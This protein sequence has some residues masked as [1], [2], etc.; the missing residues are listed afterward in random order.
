MRFLLL[1]VVVS[2]LLNQRISAAPR[3]YSAY[4]YALQ[5]GSEV[6][7]TFRGERL[8]RI[9]Q[10]LAYRPGLAASDWRVTDDATVTARVAVA[11]DCPLGIHALRLC[12]ETGISDL[13]TVYVGVLPPVDESEPN[14]S[15]QE[16]QGVPRECMILGRIQ[17]EDADRFW[18]EA[19]EGDR[20]SLE[21]HGLRLG[22]GSLFDPAIE[23]FGPDGQLVA[24][25]DDTALTQ[26]DVFMEQRALQTGRYTVC[27][28]EAVNGG[29]DRCW[30]LLHVGRYPRP[31][32]ARPEG[33]A[34]GDLLD[35]T[36][37]PTSF[38][39]R[40]ALGDAVSD[41]E[42][43]PEDEYGVAPSPLMLRVTDLVRVAETEPN[44]AVQTAQS[45]SVPCAVAATLSVPGDV[46]Q[47]RFTAAA[48]QVVDVA[49]ISRRVLRAPA[50]TVLSV[51]HVDGRFIAANDDSPGPDAYLRFTAPEGGEYNIVVRDHLDRGG[52][53]FAY[54]LELRPVQP[55]LTLYLPER[56]FNQSIVLSV[57]RGNR[58]AVMLAG[59]RQ[60]LGGPVD[61]RVE[62][63][64]EGLTVQ[65]L[66]IPADRDRIPL[67]FSAA[68]TAQPQG[69]LVPIAGQVQQGERPV[70]GK[71]HQRQ[72]LVLGLNNRDM[73]GYDADRLAVAVVREA[74]LKI[75]VHQPCVP[76]VRE[77]SLELVIR[78]ERAA[79]FT[80]PVNLQMLYAPPGV[81]SP[82]YVTLAEGATE[83]HLP[84]TAVGSAQIG[85][86]PIVV[87]A[88]GQHEG[89]SFAVASQLV[90]LR[91]EE[92]YLKLAFPQASIEQG[93]TAQ[94]TLAVE[95]HHEFDAAARAELV[96]LPPGVTAQPCEFTHGTANLVFT[97]SADPTARPGRHGGLMCR[98]RV[99]ENQEPV[100]HILGAGYLRVDMP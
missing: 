32:S 62:G 52:D 56:E 63:L 1:A 54:R 24:R 34:P 76:L 100:T 43:Y 66:T 29:D 87:I 14:N 89:D 92:A 80:A 57:P 8:S 2:G 7:V 37:T 93:T 81:S 27:V 69:Y 86:W 44:N 95:Y 12:T 33:G 9:R 30:Y 5:R 94:L 13:R 19:A 36:W 35:V 53:E 98:V 91:V 6:E 38:T 41:V 83:A 3:L 90:E 50:D 46:D 17:S 85:T 74:P 82:G 60:D 65:T 15:P 47:Y 28:H 22:N 4:P 58:A 45:I 88:E 10:M 64:P 48:G 16:A 96:G 78:A 72:V 84:L 40:I 55:A 75:E 51:R 31:V 79:G 77:G 25:A 20:L 70:T 59:A 99:S 23:L 49:T 11:A 39:E 67:L 61:V 21:V 42:V 26:Q 68:E 97:L 71:L 73:W 18:F